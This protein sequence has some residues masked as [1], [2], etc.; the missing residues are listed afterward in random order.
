MEL[1]GQG[2]T[3]HFPIPLTLRCPSLVADPMMALG[4]ANSSNIAVPAAMHAFGAL[5]SVTT[6][7]LAAQDCVYDLSDYFYTIDQSP[8][9]SKFEFL[10]STVTDLFKQ[11][12]G[13][14]ISEEIRSGLA[15]MS[16]ED[17]AKLYQ[18]MKNLFYVGK[19]D[20]LIAAV[21]LTGKRSADAPNRA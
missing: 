11:Q 18:C 9:Q 12:P 16:A 1:W 17:E 13:Q 2:L 19:T 4:A 10:S 14:D 3:E 6:S 21:Q 7:K 20:F 15:K 8:N 5:P